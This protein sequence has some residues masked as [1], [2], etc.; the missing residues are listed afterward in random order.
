MDIKSYG[1]LSKLNDILVTGEGLPTVLTAYKI[2]SATGAAYLYPECGAGRGF[3]ASG[4]LYREDRL[5]RHLT[6]DCGRGLNVGTLEWCLGQ[7][8]IRNQY[9]TDVIYR[10]RI[11]LTAFGDKP[12]AWANDPRRDIIIPRGSWSEIT[13]KF[14][15]R[16]LEMLNRVRVSE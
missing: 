6:Q 14:R 13:G 12:R 2:V 3:Y 1:Q 4:Y 8:N 5:D 10:V 11:P 9:V 16:V 7:R 15:V